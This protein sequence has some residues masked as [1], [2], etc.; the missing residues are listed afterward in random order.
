M[1]EKTYNRL[2]SEQTG[3]Y[4]EN[5][6]HLFK[7]YCHSEKGQMVLGSRDLERMP[8]SFRTSIEE[9]AARKGGSIE[10]SDTPGR[11]TDGFL[12]IYGNIEENCTFEA[13]IDANRDILKDCT[14][15]ILWEVKDD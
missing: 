10:I 11:I 15:R 9:T 3:P 7:K 12:L 2:H 14:N 4:F 8:D 5:M 13:I 1:I 6:K